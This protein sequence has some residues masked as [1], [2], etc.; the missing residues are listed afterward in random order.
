[1]IGGGATPEQPI[2]T[3]LIAIACA[4]L[5]SKEQQLRENQPP[6]IA[7]IENDHLMIDLRTVFPEEE[8]ELAAALAR[9]E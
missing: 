1:M 4:D 2:P 8:D 9:L 5:V 6:V 7:R 3:C